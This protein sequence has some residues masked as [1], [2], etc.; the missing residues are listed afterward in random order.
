MVIRHDE[1]ENVNQGVLR[2][3]L[4]ETQILFHWIG[5]KKLAY[6]IVH[7]HLRYQRGWGRWNPPPLP[8]YIRRKKAYQDKVKRF[9]TATK[10]MHNNDHKK[11]SEHK[12]YF[13]N[14]QKA[15]SSDF[16]VSLN[17]FSTKQKQSK[18]MVKLVP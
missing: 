15:I 3:A 13:R 4:L 8:T 14:S 5:L 16:Y 11:S 7:Y 9:K 2:D 1:L 12:C 10:R 17:C 18:N 6:N